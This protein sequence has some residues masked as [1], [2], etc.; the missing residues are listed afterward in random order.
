MADT[1]VDVPGCNRHAVLYR[2]GTIGPAQAQ[3][4][5][6]PWGNPDTYLNIHTQG[7]HDLAILDLNGDGLMDIINGRCIGYHVFI[8]DGP[9]FSLAVTEPTSGRASTWSWRAASPNTALYTVIATTIVNPVG[10]GP[11]FGLDPSAYTNFLT[12]YPDA[13][14][15]ATTNGS[16]GYNF[17]LPGGVPSPFPTQWRAFQLTGPLGFTLTNIAT[18]TF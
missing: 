14:V 9:P 16:G 4:L 17:S 2:N 12:L 6:D 13:P 10:S 7:T 18:I 11:F 8:Q 3:L 1:D 5:V 15:F